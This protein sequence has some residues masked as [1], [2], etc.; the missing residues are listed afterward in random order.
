MP[1]LF[2]QRQPLYAQE[3]IAEQLEKRVARIITRNQIAQKHISKE[4]NIKTNDLFN[5][6]LNHPEYFSGGDGVHPIDKGYQV[7]AEQVA[8]RDFGIFDPINNLHF[9]IKIS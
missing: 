7:L 8:E 4:K 2:G 1:S 9:F 6:I 5:L 3:K